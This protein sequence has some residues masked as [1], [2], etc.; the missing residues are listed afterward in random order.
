MAIT[1]GYKFYSSTG[2]LLYVGIT[3]NLDQRLHAHRL[4]KTWWKDVDDI[5]VKVFNTREEA[6]SYERQCIKVECP[7]YNELPGVLH[8]QQTTERI[9]PKTRSRLPQKELEYLRT[10]DTNQ[11][12]L[13]CAELQAVGWSVLSILEGAK[14]SPSPSQLRAELKYLHNVDTGVPVP[15]PPKT[16]SEK[17]QER[18]SAKRDILPWEA[19]K[20][21]EYASYSKK[22]RPQYGL[23]HPIGK[24]VQ[25]YREFVVH[26]VSEGALISDIARAAGVDESNVR[27]RYR[28]GKS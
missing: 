14:V 4:Q 21:I 6:E 9:I 20:L 3:G 28:E 25:E 5:N 22:L 16:R 12:Y 11:T 26:L 18:L 8:K 10:L 19:E 15:R 7:K 24:V 1:H 13:R 27:K 2:E 23:D 17:A